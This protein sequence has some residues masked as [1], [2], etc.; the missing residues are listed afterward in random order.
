MRAEM[1]AC[2]KR[3]SKDRDFGLQARTMKTIKYYPSQI[4]VIFHS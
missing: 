2:A 3:F 4:K 1:P